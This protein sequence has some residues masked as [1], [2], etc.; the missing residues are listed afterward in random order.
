MNEK[1]KKVLLFPFDVLYRI[2]PV[3][4]TRLMF[5][6]Q[7]KSK[8]NLEDPRTYNEKLNW[9]KL[10][11]QNELI[12]ICAD[13]FTARGYIEKC[14]Y[15]SYLP[16]LLW[17]GDDPDTIPYETLPKEFV[18]KVTSGSGHNIIV[19]NKDILDKNQTVKRIRKWL[20]EDYFIA[21]G[22]WFYNKVKPSIIIEEMLSD[23]VHEVPYDYK[24]FYFNNYYGN[25]KGGIGCTV[26]DIGRFGDHRKNIYDHEWN[27]LKEVNFDYKQAP[28][29][30]TDKPEFLDEMY[31][32]A[33]ALAAPFPHCRVDFYVIGQKFYIG[34]LTFFNGA[35]Y[36]LI[37][38]MEFNRIMGDWIKLPT[39][40]II[41]TKGN[42]DD[43]NNYA[44][45]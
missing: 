8:L 42:N 45:L 39:K 20:K 11:W 23:G 33:N 27:L 44:G 22:E 2:N 4:E 24:M 32:I 29:E 18:I 40:K 34:E 1:I 3:L 41:Y 10:F 19:H 16:K 43:L 13:K 30:L 5:R 21:Y 17:H 37:N 15:G 7:C 36:D 12:P 25:D 6:I 38:P 31:Q 9:I 35:G 26:V 28:E 14:G